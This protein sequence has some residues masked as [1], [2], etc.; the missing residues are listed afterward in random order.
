MSGPRSHNS[1]RM[2]LVT[3]YYKNKTNEASVYRNAGYTITEVMIFLAVTSAIFV[4]IAGTFNQSRRNNEF[5]TAFREMEAQIRDIANNISSGSYDNPGNI[6]CEKDMSGDLQITATGTDAQGKS[7][8]CL[9]IGAVLQFSKNGANL[10]DNSYNVYT[11]AG[12]RLR[13]GTQ[14]DVD[15]IVNAKPTSSDLLKSTRRIPVGLQWAH[16]RWNTDDLDGFGF[17]TTFSGNTDQAYK[18]LN[19]DLFKLEK[20]NNPI[21]AISSIASHK[22][23]SNDSIEICF[24]GDSVD[25]HAVFYVSSQGLLKDTEI[26]NGQCV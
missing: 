24:N 15:S 7:N 14:E 6:S 18:N 26:K 9:F 23:D 1:L 11:V 12:A 19:T 17:F 16:T 5:S 3:K 20:T 13:S 4:M 21:A 2:R 10:V 8:D 22:V 25:M